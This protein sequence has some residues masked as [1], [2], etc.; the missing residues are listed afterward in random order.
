[1]NT[2]GLGF[3]ATAYMVKELLERGVPFLT[4]EK[5]GMTKP[6]PTKS[7]KTMSFRRYFL[8]RSA[9][10]ENGTKYNPYEYYDDASLECFNVLETIV[11]DGADVSAGGK[12]SEGLTP[13]AA[14]L[15]SEDKTCSVDQYGIWTEITDMI[16]DTH[17]DPILQEATEVLGEAA[18]FMREKIYY[19]VIKAGA[20]VY[21]AG[22]TA[23]TDTDEI[24][25]LNLQRKIV[26]GLKRNLAKPITKVLSSSPNYGTEPVAPCFIGLC[27][28][29]IENDI[30]NMSNF[31]PAE[32]YSNAFEGEIG[33][34][35]NVRYISSTVIQPYAASNS[36]AQTSGM[37]RDGTYDKNIIYPIIYIAANAYATVPLK[38]KDSFTPMVLPANVPR[39]EDP[40]GQR[41]SI[42]VK[43]CTGAVI[44]NDFWMARACVTCT[45]L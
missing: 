15:E 2:S 6:L 10:T 13:D 11:G 36:N 8:S 31:V 22:G 39:G 38:G 23:T 9:F 12:L 5:F 28:S 42:G 41:G 30:M 40:L 35:E 32:R 3:R 16:Q 33:K 4:I 19:N 24:I 14:D 17:E 21:Y 29:D 18:A 43:F 25:D 26:R 37:L 27:H 44:L 20:N 1:M 7:T 45:D 34:V